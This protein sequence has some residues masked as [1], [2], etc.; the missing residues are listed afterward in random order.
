MLNVFRR[1][2]ARI[3][4]EPTEDLVAR[5]VEVY[6]DYIQGIRSAHRDEKAMTLAIGSVDQADF[7]AF[8]RMES[9][10]LRQ[11]GLEPSSCLVDVGC[12]SGRLTCQLAQW[13][14]GAYLGTDISPELLDHARAIS[15]RDDWCFQ[16]VD[17]I[18]IPSADA[19]A[20]MVCFFSVLT[21]LRHEE[22]F[23]YLKDALR[24]VRPG[25][26]IVFSFLDFAVQSH[27][28]V[29][30]AMI[31]SLNAGEGIHVNQFIS[32]DALRCWAREL[33]ADVVAIHDG[34]APHIRLSAPVTLHQGTIRYDAFGTLGQSVCIWERRLAR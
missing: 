20:D 25:G 19:S 21:H 2:Q 6:R 32:K 10:L 23:L 22:S 12:G 8:G 14:G 29:F 16:L 17:G 31:E 11:Y 33:D 9:D 15:G 3:D 18:S 34:D 26:R 24:V 13:L 5:N 7:A 1:R 4:R 27:W 28:A 30:A